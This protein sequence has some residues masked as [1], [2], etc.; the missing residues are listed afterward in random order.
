MIIS[1]V[2]L[3]LIG[4]SL[5]KAIKKNTNYHVIGFDINEAVQRS[6]LSQ[7]VV[8]EI[9]DEESLKK[10]D[11]TIISLYPE[12][13]ASFVIGNRGSFKKNSIVIDTA[14]TKMKICSMLKNA[15]LGSV[16]FVGA[17]P[18]AGR[19]VSGFENS[20]EDLFENASFIFTPYEESDALETLK[21]FSRDIGFAQ[22]IVTTPEKHDKM[23]AYTS[24]IAHVLA[25]SYVLSP[26]SLEHS[27]FSAG[28]F[29]DISRVAKINEELWTQ[30]FLENKELL[31]DEIEHL[32]DNLKKIEGFIQND[33]KIQLKNILKE[34]RLIKE[35]IDNENTK[36]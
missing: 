25:C 34:G 11:I 36:G 19:E 35:A 30:L 2:G 20:L 14:G 32:I 9:G 4:G 7:G 8:D 16:T 6:A 31:C 22:Y 27:G 21:K 1:I 24:Q 29:R 12:Q 10:T 3:G 26:N 5:A 18:M 13:V 33:D 17:H 23:I 28:S 15:D